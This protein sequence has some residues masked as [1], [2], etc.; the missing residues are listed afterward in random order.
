MSILNYDEDYDYGPRGH[1]KYLSRFYRVAVPL[2][3]GGATTILLLYMMQ[4]LI[5]SNDSIVDVDKGINLVDFVRVKQAQEVRVKQ[6]KPKKPPPPQELPPKVSKVQFNVSVN[7]QG[8]SMDDI[9][10][11]GGSDL[12]SSAFGFRSDGNYL[13]IVKVQPVYPRIALT[14][15]QEGWVVLQFTVD[16]L[17]RVVEPE[18]IDHCA[19]IRP[20]GVEE[21]CWD[22][23][24]RVFDYAAKQAARKFKYKPKVENGVAVATYN[25]RHKIT[26]EL[27]DDY[28]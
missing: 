17:G 23:P 8:F 28:E 4:S 10:I 16:E 3:L 13:P 24:D 20:I 14:R 27:M 22:Q 9:Q 18:V 21:E 12:G 11:D 26:F 25:V 5:A 15:G 19:H 7:D 6:R 2:L 1:G